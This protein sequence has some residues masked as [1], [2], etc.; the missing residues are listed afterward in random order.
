LQNADV[1]TIHV[2]CVQGGEHQQSHLKKLR[3]SQRINSNTFHK[4][5]DFISG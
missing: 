3:T 2:F 4:I 1:K 5:S